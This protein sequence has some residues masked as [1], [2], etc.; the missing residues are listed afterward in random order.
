ML[1]PTLT[2]DI[3]DKTIVRNVKMNERAATN[4]PAKRMDPFD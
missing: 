2:S 4:R 3:K 1:V